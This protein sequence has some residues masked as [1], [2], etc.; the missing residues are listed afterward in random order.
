M[1]GPVR[2]KNS[3]YIVRMEKK[4][5]KIQYL[6]FWNIDQENYIIT[7]ALREFY[8]VEIVKK[9]ANYVFCSCYGMEHLYVP[10]SCIKIYY[11]PE[12]I[13]P[14]FNFFDYALGFDYLDFGDRY[15]RLPI[16]YGTVPQQ[17]KTP[18]VDE[19]HILP[20]D[21]TIAKNKPKFCSFVVSNGN[22]SPLRQQMFE[23]LSKYKK[24]D[25]GGRFLNNI[26]GACEDKLEFTKPYKFAICFENSS[27]S[28]YTTEKITEAFAARQVPIYWG[29]PDITRVFNPKSFINVHDYSSLEDVVQE[30][31]RLDQD[32]EA[33]LNMLKEPA[34]DISEHNI[35]IYQHKLALFLKHIVDQPI[36]QA[37]RYDRVWYGPIVLDVQKHIVEQC[38]RSLK[39]HI[40]DY[41]VGRFPWLKRLLER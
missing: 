39:R 28:G 1:V 3:N 14:D 19:K 2:L 35:Y 22:G 9:D 5:I 17:K 8:D 16:Y 20:S 23:L 41:A 34:W 36:E 37:Q 24:V 30:I 10:S 40:K 13:V 29:D 21:F 15:M 31:I 38:N 25:S 18:L 32:D 26:G 4:S 33:Y 6:D 11:T 12:Y 7:K 27:M